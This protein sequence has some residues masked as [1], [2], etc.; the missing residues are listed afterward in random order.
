M[1][2]SKKKVLENYDCDDDNYDNNEKY[3]DIC[4]DSNDITTS[5]N[6]NNSIHSCNIDDDDDSDG[7]NVDDNDNDK[8][9]NDNDEDSDNIDPN[10]M[11]ILIAAIRIIMNIENDNDD[12]KIQLPLTIISPAHLGSIERSNQFVLVNFFYK[13]ELIQLKFWY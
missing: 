10:E 2:S 5:T 4:N 9:K 6:N 12:K 11:M 13:Q 1:I 8:I 7:N 3:D